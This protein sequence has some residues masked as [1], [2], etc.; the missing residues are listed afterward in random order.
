[1]L[2]CVEPETSTRIPPF[3]CFECAH[4]SATQEREA[5]RVPSFTQ[6]RRSASSPSQF[7]FGRCSSVPSRDGDDD[8]CCPPFGND[9]DDE[10]T[11][12]MFFFVFFSNKK[13]K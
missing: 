2:P 4:D 13:N 3:L 5:E 6:V 10:P 9:Y 12:K 8:E 7:V 1:M 11:V